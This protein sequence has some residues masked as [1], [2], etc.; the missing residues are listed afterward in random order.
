MSSD[1][2]TAERGGVCWS[3][4]TGRAAQICPASGLITG[5]RLR[6]QLRPV[7]V[8]LLTCGRQETMT[9]SISISTG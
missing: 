1:S 9:I 8:Q 7:L 5:L 4:Y 2:D 6:P 3:R